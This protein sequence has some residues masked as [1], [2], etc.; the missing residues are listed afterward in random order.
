MEARDQALIHTLV[1]DMAPFLERVEYPVG[2]VLWYAGDPSPDMYYVES[3]EL[4][5]FAGKSDDAA[6]RVAVVAAGDFIG[7]NGFYLQESRPAT[8]RVTQPC[9][10]QRL[11]DTAMQRMAQES[12]ALTMRLERYLLVAQTRLLVRSFQSADKAA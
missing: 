4:Q 12:P 2:H 9:V 3:G 5:L 10:L 6:T 1:A 8:M 11:S 7:I